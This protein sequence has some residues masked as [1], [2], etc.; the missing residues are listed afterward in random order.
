MVKHGIL[1]IL[2][3]GDLFLWQITAEND[4]RISRL[5][6]LTNENGYLCGKILGDNGRRCHKNRKPTR[7][8][9]PAKSGHFTEQVPDMEKSLYWFWPIISIKRGHYLGY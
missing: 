5:L 1:N 8:Q 4:E 2:Q 6:D 3:K 9:R 7:R